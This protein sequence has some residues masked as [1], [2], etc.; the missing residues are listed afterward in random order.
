MYRVIDFRHR[1]LNK[2]LCLERIR[3][4]RLYN[5]K[6]R[7]ALS[8]ALLMYGVIFRYRPGILTLIR[9]FLGPSPSAFSGKKIQNHRW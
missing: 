6:W 1:L 3:V 7:P 9:E 4:Y 2:Y 5:D 8:E